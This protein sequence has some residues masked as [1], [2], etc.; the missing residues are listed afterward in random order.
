[1]VSDEKSKKLITFVT[2][3]FLTNYNLFF[4]KCLDNSNSSVDYVDHPEN[5][6]LDNVLPMS[7]FGSLTERV[8]TPFGDSTTESVT[9]NGSI[10]PK[11]HVLKTLVQAYPEKVIFPNNTT[12]VSVKVSPDLPTEYVYYYKWDISL[13]TTSAESTD[14]SKSFLQDMTDEPYLNVPNLNAGQYRFEVTINFRDHPEISH[15]NLQAEGKFVVPQGIKLNKSR[16]L[17]NWQ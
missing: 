9:T 14:E 16:K 10:L 2:Y 12:R 11:L 5:V 15:K 13:R 4:L 7:P 3:E 1:M 8:R 17:D 6:I